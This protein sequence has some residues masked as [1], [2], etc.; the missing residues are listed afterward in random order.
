VVAPE[1]FIPAQEPVIQAPPL[2]PPRNQLKLEAHASFP[3]RGA[4]LEFIISELSRRKIP[5]PKDTSVN[6]ASKTAS[7][8]T[9][10][11]GFPGAGLAEAY[12]QRA[13]AAL[14]RMGPAAGFCMG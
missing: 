6:W 4:G 9:L 12:L 10:I 11:I 14:H 1:P 5:L 7:W 13:N 2:P 8:R 3:L